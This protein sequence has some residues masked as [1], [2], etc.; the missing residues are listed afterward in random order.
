MAKKS[1]K[2]RDLTLVDRRRLLDWDDEDLLA[3]IQADYDES[4]RYFAQHATDFARFDNI[5]DTIHGENVVT[6]ARQG[7]GIVIDPKKRANMYYPVGRV[8]LDT[9]VATVIDNI[10]PSIDF[11][12]VIPGTEWEYPQHEE[13][14]RKYLQ[15]ECSPERMNIRMNFFHWLLYAF[16]YR[17][18]SARIEFRSSG[19]TVLK[20]IEIGKSAVEEYLRDNKDELVAKIA[21]ELAANM[22]QAYAGPKFETVYDPKAIQRPDMHIINPYDE[23]NDFYAQDYDEQCRY[24]HEE[25]SISWTD[26]KAQ[27]QSDEN[28]LGLYPTDKIKEIEK[29]AY[30][31]W[32][33]SSASAHADSPGNR[34]NAQRTYDRD[35]LRLRRYST[36]NCEIITDCNYK[37]VLR[38][39]PSDGWKLSKM[40]YWP[41]SNRWEGYSLLELVET[42]NIDYNGIKNS[43][44]DNV[45]FALDCLT[46]INKSLLSNPNKEVVRFPGAT[47]EVNGRPDDVVKF[48]RPPDMSAAS[49]NEAQDDL[50]W[51]GK[52]VPF[53]ENQQGQYRRGIPSAT[54]TQVVNERSSMRIYP[55]NLM[56]EQHNLAWALKRAATEIITNRTTNEHFVIAGSGA[57]FIGTMSVEL[58]SKYG[59]GM[60][61]IP[62]GSQAEM[63][64]WRDTLAKRELA[65]TIAQTPMQNF[66]KWDE[67]TRMLFINHKIHNPEQYLKTGPNALTS[68]PPKFEHIAMMNGEIVAP[69]DADDVQDHITQH[70]EFMASDEYDQLDDEIK[71]LFETHLSLTEKQLQGMQ[72]QAPPGQQPNLNNML[73]GAKTQGQAIA[74]SAPAAVSGVGA[75]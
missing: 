52:V 54:E 22:D 36:I 66:V 20:K 57:R 25:F 61:I 1:K 75:V 41:R 48:D 27:E 10:F 8:V 21:D 4:D 58:I 13:T 5:Y 47:L 30:K 6:T 49:E 44:R 3:L 16:K 40:Q 42:L 7:G 62:F 17:W 19:D 60:K 14:W 55:V 26:I 64:K 46:V 29:E 12:D 73:Q 65:M 2:Q 34:R 15:Y 51:V 70:Q 56:I 71:I 28:P 35:V 72:G 18:G 43:R 24:H 68:I 32:A 31:F 50:A 53:G 33:A 59:I 9:A 45:N 38:R 11:F 23:R 74:A 67:F 69:S 37:V 63:D 39:R